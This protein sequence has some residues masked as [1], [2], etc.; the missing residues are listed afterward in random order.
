MNEIIK[1][2]LKNIDIGKVNEL[3][4]KLPKDKDGK[5]DT[6]LVGKIAGLIGANK[7]GLMSILP[8]AID[9]SGGKLDTGS[10]LSSIDIKDIAKIF[11]AAAAVGVA[12]TVSKAASKKIDEATDKIQV[13][14]S[15]AWK[16]T[17]SK[18]IT[19]AADKAAEYSNSD[20]SD[21][22][23]LKSYIEFAQSVKAS[24]S[25]RKESLLKAGVDRYSDPVAEMNTALSR[26]SGAERKLTE[27][28]EAA[29]K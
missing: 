24:A 17:S 9:K 27:K 8:K 21:P 25:A 14:E 28:L 20:T 1:E 26:A 10:L 7:D 12:H 19:A 15:T 3:L 22:N 6:D 18:E 16:S 5:L 13:A 4:G 2:L 29:G 23:L 11:P